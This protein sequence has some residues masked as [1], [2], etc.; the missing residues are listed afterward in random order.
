MRDSSRML[1]GQEQNQLA[2]QSWAQSQEHHLKRSSFQVRSLSTWNT[3]RGHIHPEE[4][5]RKINARH[6]SS[7]VL[8]GYFFFYAEVSSISLFRNL[9][10][11]LLD[12][13]SE[14]F[15]FLREY[16]LLNFHRTQSPHTSLPC[17]YRKDLMESWTPHAILENTGWFCTGFNDYK[18]ISQAL[19]PRP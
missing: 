18:V 3:G 5:R 13:C 9:S 17:G 15:F 12:L 1:P 6:F 7:G 19:G 10:A 14:H 11:P 4:N 16:G 8:A 2:A